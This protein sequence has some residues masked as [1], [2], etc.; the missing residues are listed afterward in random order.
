MATC[1]AAL[2]LLAGCATLDPP[3][4]EE[5]RAQALPQVDVP[6]QWK[7]NP[8]ARAGSIG[9]GWVTTFGDPQLDALVAEAIANNP[10][11]QIAAARVEQADAAV[12]AAKAQLRPAIGI[13]GRTS[14]KPVSDLIPILS[15]VILRAW[16]E[17][18]L[19]GRLRYERN[20]ARAERDAAGADYRFAQQSIAASTA[21][22]WFLA[23]ATA[24]Q[25]QLSDEMARN[26]AKLVELAEQR[27]RVGA[28][29]GTDVALARASSASYQDAA[30]QV[31]LAHRQALRA[32]EL[33]L[34]RYPAAEIQSRQ[35]LAAF[36]GPIPVGVPLEALERRPD[37]IA[38][39]RRVAAAFN[40]TRAAKAARLPSLTL[41]ANFGWVN[42]D[43]LEDV[44]S[45]RSNTT[46]SAGAQ[47]V[48]PIYLGGAIDSQIQLRSAEQ[49]QAVAEYGRLALRALG[50]VEDALD[51]ENIF[52]QREN[53]LRGA[54]DDSR[55]AL[56]LERTSYRVGKADLRDV[57]QSQLSS[58]ATEIALLQVRREHLDRRVD[59]HLALGGNFV[60]TPPADAAGA[61]AG[62]SSEQK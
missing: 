60:V 33:L 38:A 39:E 28:G 57:T 35:D 62:A 52:G 49:K 10:D 29:T 37:L 25:Q 13:L 46:K 24:R 32:L 53:I 48:Q 8:A 34:G 14:T 59:L 16:W 9:D 58:F 54:L 42:T 41:S 27:E 5:I 51:A 1:A 44:T 11:L 20:A 50:E 36:P 26:A 15:G 21:R 7:V 40:R 56:D 55:R 47:V 23:A 3:S 43:D 45:E 22:A 61:D 19:W 31:E 17:L 12:E 18:D 2:V 6:A 4:G 30:Q